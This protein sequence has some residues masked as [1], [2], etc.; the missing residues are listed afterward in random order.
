MWGVL[1][2]CQQRG[3]D[4]HHVIFSIDNVSDL[5]TKAK[6]L[7]YVDTLR[8]M[9][10]LK[11]NVKLCIGMYKGILEDS[12]IVRG[13]DFD[14]HIRLSGYVD[15]HESI[16][17]IRGKSMLCEFEFLSGGFDRAGRMLQVTANEAMTKTVWT[18]RPDLNIY[19][20]LED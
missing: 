5:H 4:M 11:G 8:A 14:K 16:L 19:W 6:F 3:C 13:D 20:T 9:N 17:H 12:F 2:D 15:K 7:R 1:L 18:Y 10:V